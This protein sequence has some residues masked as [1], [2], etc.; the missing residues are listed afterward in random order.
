MRDAGVKSISHYLYGLKSV[1]YVIIDETV[2]LKYLF[3][4]FLG[5]EK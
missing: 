1:S 3:L 4:F 5:A 2:R